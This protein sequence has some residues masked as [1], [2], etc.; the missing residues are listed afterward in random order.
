[1]KNITKGIFMEQLDL[2]KSIEY[3]MRPTVYTGVKPILLVAEELVTQKSVGQVVEAVWFGINS[4]REFRYISKFAVSGKIVLGKYYKPHEME[5]FKGRV[6]LIND[7]NLKNVVLHKNALE[8]IKE[9]KSKQAA[10][11]ATL[12]RDFAS[13][14]DLYLD[15]KEIYLF[16]KKDG[17]WEVELF[18]DFNID[19]PYKVFSVQKKADELH[20]YLKNPKTGLTQKYLNTEKFYGYIIGSKADIAGLKLKSESY[21]QSIMI[22]QKD[23]RKY[24]Q[25]IEWLELEDSRVKDIA[26]EL[27]KHPFEEYFP[28]VKKEDVRRLAVSDELV[29]SLKAIILKHMPENNTPL[30]M[31]YIPIDRLI[32]L[33]HMIISRDEALEALEACDIVYEPPGVVLGHGGDRKLPPKYLVP[34]AQ[35]AFAYQKFESF[36]S[37]CQGFISQKAHKDDKIPIL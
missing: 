26:N 22:L 9:F 11:L 21:L 34:I 13:L 8:Q 29:A 6:A 12:E 5:P 37:V 23:A 30:G 27:P 18:S 3:F 25:D 28:Y 1:M 19:A 2:A 17:D 36:M 16:E 10:L 31:E 7:E 15:N 32:Y 33:F 24:I 35:V 20:L 14:Q 4:D